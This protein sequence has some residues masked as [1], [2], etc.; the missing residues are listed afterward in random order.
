MLKFNM[1]DLKT[2]S[3]RTGC[4]AC[5]PQDLVHED[6]LE[7]G[8]G[9]PRVQGL[10]ILK[11]RSHRL[12]GDA[13]GSAAGGKKASSP[14]DVAGSGDVAETAANCAAVGQRTWVW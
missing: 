13:T 5:E 4:L 8:R 7:A 6:S 12:K 1:E 3:W 2:K 9:W 14:A 11:P 10:V